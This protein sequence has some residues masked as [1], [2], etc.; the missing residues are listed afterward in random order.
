MEE[1]TVSTDLRS[2][3]S[4]MN[5]QMELR[6]LYREFRS[7]IDTINQV[8]ATE[9]SRDNSDNDVDQE[10]EDAVDNDVELILQEIEL[11]QSE[12]E[13]I[14]SLISKPR[15]ARNKRVQQIK[16]QLTHLQQ[17]NDNLRV[18]AEALLDLD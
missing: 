12:T 10:D 2:D 5:R 17:V 3:V 11:M 14:I 7:A 16:K 4:F 1:Q 18:R 13:E 8:Q 6:K 9:S 15:F